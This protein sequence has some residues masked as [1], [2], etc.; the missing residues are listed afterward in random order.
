MRS[1]E[2]RTGYELITTSNFRLV[3]HMFIPDVKMG[4]QFLKEIGDF[5]MDL[6][7]RKLTQ[8]AVCWI[9]SLLGSPRKVLVHC[10]EN[11]FQNRGGPFLGEI[12]F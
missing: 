2:E 10:H 5:L 4:L 7:R 8:V 6:R 9:N 11:L 3:T 1:M 12:V